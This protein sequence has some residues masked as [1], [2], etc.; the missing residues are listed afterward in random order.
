MNGT[1]GVVARQQRLG[2]WAALYLALALIAAMPYFLLVVDYQGA[3]TAADKVALIVSNYPSM[4]AMYF[5][6]YIFFGFALGVLALELHDRLRA[7]APF[8][9]RLAAGAGAL[10]AVALVACGMVYTYGMTT[11]VRL[12]EADA[13]AAAAT[14]Q[15]IE[16][17]ALGLGGAGGEV[18]GGLWVLLVSVIALRARVLP[19]M[20]AWLGLVVGAA[21]LASAVPALN[22][23]VMA[24][25]VLQI[26]WLAWLGVAL[27]T[28]KAPAIT[29]GVAV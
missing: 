22:D 17:V 4:Y 7:D 21:G 28:A 27:L 10:W 1:N 19:R 3:T 18:L 23:A 20:L 29:G 25:G 9:S 2:G 8:A 5:V 26:V 12:A 15:G 16:P 13:A 14:W 6:T 24:F 11:I